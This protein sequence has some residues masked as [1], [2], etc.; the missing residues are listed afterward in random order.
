M[1]SPMAIKPGSRLSLIFIP[2]LQKTYQRRIQAEKVKV[3]LRS[4]GSPVRHADI[5]FVIRVCGRYGKQICCMQHLPGLQ[6]YAAV[7]R[8]NRCE[9]SALRRR[10]HHQEEQE[11]GK[12]S[13]AAV[14]T[15][16]QT[17]LRVKKET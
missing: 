15:Q 16:M 5:R 11:G 1:Q 2:R 6:I 10:Y 3:A 17:S 14:I 8:E 4:W 13:M 12:H 7:C 9:V